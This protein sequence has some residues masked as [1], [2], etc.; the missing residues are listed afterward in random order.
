[1]GIFAGQEAVEYVSST[2]TNADGSKSFSCAVKIG[3]RNVAKVDDCGSREEAEARAASRA[4]TIL[5]ERIS[6][7]GPSVNS[8]KRKLE[9]L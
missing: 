2:S 1:M 5:K 8:R 3:D 6:A 9:I 4:A 7:D